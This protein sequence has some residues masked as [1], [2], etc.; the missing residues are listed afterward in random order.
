[1]TISADTDSLAADGTALFGWQAGAPPPGC[2]PASAHSASLGVAA[3]LSAHSA[4]LG[5][6]INHAQ[7]VR[8]EGGA[9]TMNT[10]AML[11][12]VDERSAAAISGQASASG[13][14]SAPIALASVSDPVLLGIPAMPPLPA[15]PGEAHAVAVHSGPGSGSYRSLA[16]YWHTQAV[17]LGNIA[18][19]MSNASVSVDASWIDGHQTAG[20]NIAKHGT[21]WSDLAGH[22]SGLATA[23]NEAADLHDQWVA[24][25]PT[26]QEFADAHKQLHQAKTV[27][28]QAAAAAQLAQ[29][30][31]QAIDAAAAHQA[32]S[33]ATLNA[34]PAPPGTA[35]Q[36]A[37]GCGC[38][39]SNTQGGNGSVNPIAALAA[40]LGLNPAQ[41]GLNPGAGAAGMNAG[42]SAGAGA[43][44]MDSTL[45]SMLPMLAMMAPMAAMA[46]MSALS[47]LGGT[48]RQNTPTPTAQS[49]GWPAD[50][51]PD[52][53]VSSDLGDTVPASGGGGGVDAAA[54]AAPALPTAGPSAP[55]PTAVSG[56]A[57]SLLTP[58]E[59]AATAPASTTGSGGMSTYPP[60]MGAPAAG[61]TGSARDMRLFPDRR[62]VSR[63]VPNTEAVFGELPRERRP[64]AKRAKPEER[65]NEAS[66]GGQQ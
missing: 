12:A 24:A 38:D 50:V 45:Q 51:A 33:S 5:L 62:M 15:V 6:L 7:Q 44:G 23:A 43:G 8:V 57:A 30:H 63:P 32:A 37:N 34:I 29:L 46:P 59:G 11:R 10:A 56:P 39:G 49:A 31:G 1:M 28:Q 16:D 48:G 4:S 64:R 41:L 3:Q 55:S 47:G 66:E 21:W 20:A 18:G 60:M 54:A 9:A 19:D 52:A 35:P 27:A 2:E 14:A 58:A 13:A 65:T 40:Q 17:A 53:A 42:A 61:D 22:A 36:I 25:T 26:T